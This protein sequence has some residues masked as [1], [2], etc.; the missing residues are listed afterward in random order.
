M[1]GSIN[2]GKND[3]EVSKTKRDAYP[4]FEK[5]LQ[6]VLEWKQDSSR[7]VDDLL[8]EDADMDSPYDA[9]MENL[10]RSRTG[11]TRS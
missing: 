11:R 3:Y 10:K 1:T 2:T 8:E 7:F 5:D 9:I 4:R 6:K